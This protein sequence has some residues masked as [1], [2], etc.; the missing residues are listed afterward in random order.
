MEQEL[1][2]VIGMVCE[3]ERY[4]YNAKTVDTV[5]AEKDAEIAQLKDKL[6]HYPIMTKLIDNGNKEI[7]ELKAKLERVQASMDADL[8]DAGMENRRLKR[9]LWLMRAERYKMREF[10]AREEANWHD[11]MA[12]SQFIR[13]RTYNQWV[14]QLLRIAHLANKLH[15]KC[16]ANAEEYK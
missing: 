14:D 2:K 12:W 15:N 8:I 6:R 3:R 10:I 7:A 1:N 13:K 5:L 9:A 16:L 11:L 4:Y